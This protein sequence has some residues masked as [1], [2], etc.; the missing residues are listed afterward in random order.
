MKFPEISKIQIQSIIAFFWFVILAVFLFAGLF[1]LATAA[2]TIE[3]FFAILGELGIITIV[4]IEWLYKSVNGIEENH[5]NTR[6]NDIEAKIDE[7]SKP[8]PLFPVI[9]K[10]SK[11]PLST[12]ATQ[13]E[14]EPKFDD[15]VEKNPPLPI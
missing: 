4:I 11:D 6:L 2:I 9:P 12:K 5:I 3:W 14:N 1:L 7:A 10:N 8:I 15:S 13:D